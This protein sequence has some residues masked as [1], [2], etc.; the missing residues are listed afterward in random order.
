MIPVSPSPSSGHAQHVP[1]RDIFPIAKWVDSYNA[2]KWRG[3]VFALEEAVPFV[4][5][6]ALEI[7]SAPPYHLRFTSEATEL[8]KIPHPILP[9]YPLV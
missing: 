9:E 3:H 4:N 2:I 1:L 8:C 5:A 6:A 7:L